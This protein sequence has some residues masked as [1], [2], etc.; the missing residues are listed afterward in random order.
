MDRVAVQLHT[1]K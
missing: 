1:M